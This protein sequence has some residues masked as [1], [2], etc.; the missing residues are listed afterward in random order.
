GKLIYISDTVNPETRTVLVRTELANPGRK[1]KPAMLATMV[2]AGKASPKLAVPAAA[3]VREDNNEHVFVQT[4]PS[5]YRLTP[6]V[7][8]PETGGVR[9]VQS[10]L[11]EGDSVVVEGA[12][13]LNNERKRKELEGG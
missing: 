11:K 3:V 2:I 5:Q 10:G 12:F 7:L 6:V 13:H 8:G 4:A 1:L 9:P